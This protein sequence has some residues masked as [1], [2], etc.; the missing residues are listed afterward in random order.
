MKQ[1]LPLA[2]RGLYLFIDKTHSHAAAVE[3]TVWGF[4]IYDDQ[5]P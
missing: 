4:Q 1:L 3:P 5:S 2:H